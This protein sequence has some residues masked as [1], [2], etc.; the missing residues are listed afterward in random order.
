MGTLSV[1]STD[2]DGPIVW[3]SIIHFIL[4]MNVTKWIYSAGLMCGVHSLYFVEMKLSVPP[5]KLE[6]GF[7]C[8]SKNLSCTGSHQAASSGGG[9][10]ISLC[11]WQH[12][13]LDHICRN[14]LAC[15]FICTPTH[16]R[17]SL[18]CEGIGKCPCL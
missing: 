17:H 15:P 16:C 12:M 1:D 18:M 14:P 5:K 7:F 6:L 8:F 10:D 13:I 11:K 9:I 3:F 4:V 2:L